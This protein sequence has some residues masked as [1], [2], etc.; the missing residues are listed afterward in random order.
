MSND[1]VSINQSLGELKKEKFLTIKNA[2][3]LESKKIISCPDLQVG[4]KDKNFPSRGLV[5]PAKGAPVE[6]SD[7]LYNQYGTL[8]FDGI[9]LL[10]GTTGTGTI[11]NVIAGGGITSTVSSGVATI[12]VKYSAGTDIISS[13]NDGTTVTIDPINDKV[14]ILDN[15]DSTVKYVNINQ[16]AAVT[17]DITAVTAG[18]GLTGGGA[19]G[20]VTLNINDSI[21]A[22]L[23][24]SAFSGHVIP[25]DDSTYNLGSAS[26]RWANIYTGDLHLRNE[27]GNWTIV[28]EVDY[29]TVVNNIT[30]KKYKMM[31]EP[32]D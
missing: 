7:K 15:T 30:G 12:E 18:I 25:S 6:T 5:F 32:I 29:L 1:E 27:R 9:P 2:Q 28:E 11:T 16:I 24:G 8:Y 26:N 13:A 4:L 21:V 31:L 10:S 20:D 14:I 19:F 23:S 3:T 22:T 17:G